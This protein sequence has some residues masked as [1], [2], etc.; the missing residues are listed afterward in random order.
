M[1]IVFFGTPEF[2]V[3][4]L[5]AMLAGPHTVVGVVCQPDRPA[6]RGQQ[7]AVPPVKRVAA[8]AEVPVLQPEK[9][10]TAEF[11][12][13]LRA[14][15]PDLIVVAA[16]G[17]ILPATILELPPRGCINVHASL[18]PKYRGAAPIQWAILRGETTTGVTI[19]Q[20]VEAMDAGAILLQRDVPIGPADTGG[21]L[22]TRLAQVGAELL[23]EAL[24][25][26][27]AG[28]LRPTPQ[29]EAAATFAPMIRKE[30]G[31]IDWRHPALQISRTVRAFNPWPSAF[32]TLGGKVLKIHRARAVEDRTVAAPG[33]V[34]TVSA[35]L[36]VA[37]GSGHL[38]VDELQLEGR[39]RLAARDFARGGQVTRGL[40][41]GSQGGVSK[42]PSPS[43]S[44][45]AR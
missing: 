44:P 26:L 18:L 13:A 39:K 24:E 7:V 40:V 31:R 3:P 42:V 2:A 33:T 8:D 35:G 20:M 17:R 43:G 15:A 10:R 37:T 41:L 16:Y 23:L 38:I 36:T 21:E 27:E 30:D 22:Q 34:L 32:T 19:M 28:R 5:R 11:L 6:G 1:R 29:D 4:S 9:V 45:P 12:D 25:R 14:W